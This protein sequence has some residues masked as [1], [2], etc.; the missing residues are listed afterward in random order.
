MATTKV[1]HIGQCDVCTHVVCNNTKCG[2]TYPAKKFIR[3]VN[4]KC[5]YFKHKEKG[6]VVN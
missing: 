3:K 4:K 5:Y 6:K 1:F 2:Y